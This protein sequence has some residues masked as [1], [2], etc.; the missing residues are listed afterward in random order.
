[1][2]A[3]ST[4]REKI[5]QVIALGWLLKLGTLAL[6]GPYGMLAWGE[7]SALLEGRQADIAALQAERA[8]LENRVT[9]LDPDNVDPDF[10][11]ELVRHNLNVAHRDEYVIDLNAQP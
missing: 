3:T 11:S 9:L 5:I 10:A 4:K 1:M 8:V 2:N 7:K 6:A